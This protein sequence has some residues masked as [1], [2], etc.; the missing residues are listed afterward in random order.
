MGFCR[1]RN[2]S[3]S[4]RLTWSIHF[5]AKKPNFLSVASDAR[6][7]ICSARNSFAEAALNNSMAPARVES[8]ARYGY[9]EI[10]GNVWAARVSLDWVL[11]CETILETWVTVCARCDTSR[12]K[13][14]NHRKMQF[15][16]SSRNNFL[17]RHRRHVKNEIN[18]FHLCCLFCQLH[19]FRRK[20]TSG[21]TFVARSFVGSENFTVFLTVDFTPHGLF[22][23]KY[24]FFQFDK[25]SKEKNIPKV[26]LDTSSRT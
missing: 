9:D 8:V 14:H 21:S 6:H 1:L 4:K 16:L 17:P 25:P 13:M 15:K 10:Y 20:S 19:V 3:I 5:E 23:A 24:H 22:S 12:C 7:S 2:K 18:F 26:R 11:G